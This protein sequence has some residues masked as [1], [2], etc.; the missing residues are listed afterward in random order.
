MKKIRVICGQFAASA[1]RTIREG[2]P[3]S[4]PFRSAVF[5]LYLAVFITWV[6]RWELRTWIFLMVSLAFLPTLLLKQRNASGKELSA[7]I[8][9]IGSRAG[10][11]SALI[12][13]CLALALYLAVGYIGGRGFTPHLHDEFAYIFQARTFALGRLSLPAPPIP[14]FFE[15]FHLL[16]E[17][18]YASK[19][20]PG[21]ALVMLPGVL[22]GFPILMSAM[23]SAGSL[24]LFYLIVKPLQNRE[25]ALICLVVFALSP[26]Q[27]Q[28]AAIHLSHTSSLF[29][30]LLFVYLSGIAREKHKGLCAFSA[31][32]ALGIAFLVRPVTALAVGGPFVIWDI[33]TTIKDAEPAKIRIKK[34]VHIFSSAFA[35]MLIAGLL[36]AYNFA[37]MGDPLSFP[38]V[39]YAEKYIPMDALG[40]HQDQGP[41][42]ALQLNLSPLMTEFNRDYV[43]PLKRQYS[44]WRAVRQFWFQRLP[45]T[46]YMSDDSFCLAAFLPFAFV[47]P[48]TSKEK[49]FL[50][51]AFSLF[52]AHFF[53]Y[54]GIPRYHFEVVP[55]LIYFFVKGA[56]IF[57][58]TLVTNA[59][60]FLQRFI[61]FHLMSGVIVALP[62]NLLNEF[63]S[64][65]YFTRYHAEFREL[66]R[67]L[68]DSPK[69]IFVR[70]KPEHEYHYDLINNEP[71][72]KNSKAIYV[73][74]M[75][76][77][78]QELMRVFPDRSFY[79]FDEAKW[80]IER[81]TD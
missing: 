6:Y 18:V 79:R 72:L 5:L 36:F 62:Y 70:Y 34:I 41:Q 13:T 69:L 66:V 58:R 15:S 68:D 46:I 39:E 11:R 35:F 73:H 67:R 81:L 31:G 51:S 52:F 77:R 4:S 21:Q 53:Y 78:N 7:T 54:G 32:A 49:V 64:K 2:G 45:D 50:A 60:P 65:R 25:C 71:D 48:L 3:I 56:L 42:T 33:W 19:Y 59:S 14:E 30:L 1:T 22:L 75:G 38:W 29:F 80:E 26:L 24:L 27:I 55:I 74:D 37:V 8:E 76:E 44:F 12:A 23:L 17:K 16:T 40:F 20:P 63:N 10:F 47:V 9:R 57:S 61:L 43:E 28:L